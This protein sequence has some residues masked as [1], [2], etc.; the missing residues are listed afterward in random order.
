MADI[1][2]RGVFEL[3]AY[4]AANPTGKVTLSPIFVETG[5]LIMF[6]GAHAAGGLST[7][8]HVSEVFGEYTFVADLVGLLPVYPIIHLLRKII[9]EQHTMISSLKSFVLSDAQCRNDFDREFIQNAIIAW[10]GSDKKFED[11]V[12][13]HLREELLGISS[14]RIPLPYIGMVAASVI[15]GTLDCIMALIRGKAPAEVVATHFIGYTLAMSFCWFFVVLT[16]ILF[17][18]DRWAFPFCKGWDHLTSLAIFGLFFG[19]F[20]SGSRITRAACGKSLWAAVLWFLFT[21]A[22]AAV[23]I[24]Q[25]RMFSDSRQS[26][27]KV[28][29]EDG[30]DR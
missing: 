4:H 26:P 2:N 19:T 12:R 14:P 6:V 15:S 8:I 17:L 1:L 7:L 9:R 21:F 23:L 18:S 16:M 28:D 24:R 10:Y 27:V 13:D 5:V 22:V 30:P 29:D 11:F 25:R 20:F 3:A